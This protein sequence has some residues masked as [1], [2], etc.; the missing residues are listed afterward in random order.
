VFVVGSMGKDMKEKLKKL[1][2]DEYRLGV[3]EV[4]GEMVFES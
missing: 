2:D 4:G 1:V 3:D